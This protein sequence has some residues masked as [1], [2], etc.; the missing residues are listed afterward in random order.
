MTFHA[1]T[2]KPAPGTTYKTAQRIRDTSC[3]RLV[4]VSPDRIERRT[5]PDKD[6]TLRAPIYDLPL[7]ASLLGPFYGSEYRHALR[8]SFELVHHP[9]K[10]PRRK[11]SGAWI[12]I[13]VGLVGR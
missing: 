13:P 3:R 6:T 1:Y 9:A 10:Y 5:E 12:E 11:A 2:V 4:G 8:S 7:S